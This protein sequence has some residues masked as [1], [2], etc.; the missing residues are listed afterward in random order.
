MK[1]FMVGGTGLLGAAGASILIERGHTVSSIALPPIPE[2]ANIPKEM[3]II[4]KSYMD[5]NEED[6]VESMQ[7]CEGFIFAAGVDERVEFAP[8]VYE[9]Y[10][11][12]NI[13]PLIKMLKAAKKCGIKKT[14]ILGSYFSHFAKIW[15]ELK[16]YDN[17]PYIRSRIDQEN[18]ALSFA[19]GDMDVTILELPYIF[20]AQTGR[21]PVWMLF[22]DMFLPQKTI[23]FAKGGTTMVTVRQVAECIAGAID[24]PF[25]DGA[26]CYPVGWYNMQWKQLISIFNKYMGFPDKKIVTVP[27]LLVKLNAKKQLKHNME[28]NI[29]AG[30][31][32]VEFPKLLTRET[33][34]DK[35]LIQKELK[36]TEDDIDEAIG[37][38]IKLCMEI[39]NQNIPVVEMKADN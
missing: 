24:R 20:G 18:A 39:K 17:H 13:A 38:S 35:E 21:K 12:Y 4:L 15:P 16:L 26:K 1:I 22:V 29:E 34:I 14:V 25:G 28:N 27:T 36:V 11:K 30:L 10:Y 33:Y 23:Y 37:E 9:S 7:G 32:P 2:G 19:D 31:N 8:P 3:N 6:F 5:M